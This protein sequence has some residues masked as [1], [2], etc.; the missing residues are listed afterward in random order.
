MNV[1]EPGHPSCP[2]TP[3]PPEPPTKK[4][5]HDPCESD[6]D[7]GEVD[8]RDSS[9]NLMCIKDSGACLTHTG[10]KSCCD[11]KCSENNYDNQGNGAMKFFLYVGCGF[12]LYDWKDNV[13]MQAT[14]DTA[15]GP[16]PV[17][18]RLNREH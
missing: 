5:Q 1:T 13:C 10:E 11:I 3:A 15:Q 16:P 7:C 9:K 12:E 14:G 4:R 8:C 6:S 18:Y 2:D 17:D